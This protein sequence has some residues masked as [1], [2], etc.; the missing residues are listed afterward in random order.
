LGKETSVYIYA[1]KKHH[2]NEITECRKGS[3]DCSSLELDSKSLSD[4]KAISK[5]ELLKWS[6]QSSTEAP[7]RLKRKKRCKSRLASELAKL[8]KTP[9]K[10]FQRFEPEEGELDVSMLV[11]QLMTKYPRFVEADAKVLAESYL[12]AVNS[13]K[14]VSE[15]RHK[16]IKKLSRKELKKLVD[17]NHARMKKALRQLSKKFVTELCVNGQSQAIIEKGKRG[18]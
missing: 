7:K 5:D 2:I 15:G 18:R 14:E 16:L 11:A 8:L 9:Y 10:V 4:L 1:E 17:N 12:K 3:S 13:K 6:K